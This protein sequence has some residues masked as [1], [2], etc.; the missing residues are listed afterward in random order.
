MNLRKEILENK[1]EPKLTD[2]VTGF[3]DKDFE[4]MTMK[5]PLRKVIGVDVEN[6]FHNGMPIERRYEM[7]EC[8][9]R[10]KNL[11]IL[12]NNLYGTKDAFRR[13]CYECLRKITEPKKD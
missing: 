9:H 10:G 3:S 1:E 13:R 2:K 6:G 12:N 8:G 5:A 4:A 11:A 7:L